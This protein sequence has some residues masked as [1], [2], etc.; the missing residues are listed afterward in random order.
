MAIGM[1]SIIFIL[2][3]GFVVISSILAKSEESKSYSHLPICASAHLCT[4]ENFF[5]KKIQKHYYGFTVTNYVINGGKKLKG[6]ITVNASKN[7]AVAILLA[8]L[9]NEG[10]TTIT[11]LPKN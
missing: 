6:E 2:I 7:S 11:N 10:K 5:C 8:S 9:L 4:M 3:S 1:T